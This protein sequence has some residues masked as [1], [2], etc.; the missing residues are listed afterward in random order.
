[1]GLGLPGGSRAQAPRTVLGTIPSF[2]VERAY[3]KNASE[4][5]CPELPGAVIHHGTE[6][7]FA[8]AAMWG[9]QP[10]AAWPSALFSN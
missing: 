5:K 2:G 4:P 9:W 3:Q 8:L 7:P 10:E 1:M 6:L